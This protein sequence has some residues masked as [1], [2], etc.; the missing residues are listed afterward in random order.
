MNDNYL[1][2]FAFDPFTPWPCFDAIGEVVCKKY[3]ISKKKGSRDKFIIFVEFLI[4]I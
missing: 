2:G 1:N 4:A 3:F